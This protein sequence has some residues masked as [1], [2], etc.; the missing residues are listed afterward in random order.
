MIFI[1]KFGVMFCIV[2]YDEE[3]YSKQNSCYVDVKFNMNVQ[4]VEVVWCL[5]GLEELRV[6]CIVISL[7]DD[8]ND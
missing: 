2:F 5:L 3:V 1:N 8:W 7:C 6:C 4:C